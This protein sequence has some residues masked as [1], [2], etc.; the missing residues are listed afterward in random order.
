MT[1][2]EALKKLKESD[3]M[4]YKL[5]TSD[6]YVIEGGRIYNKKYKRWLKFN[7]GT[8]EY[9]IWIDGFQKRYS[10]FDIAKW[11]ALIKPTPLI[12]VDI[13]EVFNPKIKTVIK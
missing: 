6:M 11:S 4:L 13:D 2:E 9:N 8:F 7:W 5:F 12:N 3:P 10:C 1:K